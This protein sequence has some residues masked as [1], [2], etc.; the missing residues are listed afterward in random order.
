MWASL[1]VTRLSCSARITWDRL[2][3]LRASF[4]IAVL[5]LTDSCVER[6][7]VGPFPNGEKL[8]RTVRA[9]I[10]CCQSNL[11]QKKNGLQWKKKGGSRL[12]LTHST[13]PSVQQEAVWPKFTLPHLP[14]HLFSLLGKHLEKCLRERG[15]KK[16][17]ICLNTSHLV[18]GKVK[19]G[20]LQT[21]TAL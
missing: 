8:S 17:Y 6:R 13:H 5:I 1:S 14:R 19:P 4:A 3:P 12:T 7:F 20:H 2:T 10:L 11:Q 9:L 16:E 15:G 18:K 21:Y